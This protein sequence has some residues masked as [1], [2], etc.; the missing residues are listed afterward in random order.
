M[1]KSR[2]QI[3]EEK[4]SVLKELRNEVAQRPEPHWNHFIFDVLGNIIDDYKLQLQFP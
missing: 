4:L 1:T 3:T 2:K